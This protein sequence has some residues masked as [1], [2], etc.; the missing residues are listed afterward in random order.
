M[1]KKVKKV[2]KSSILSK[3]MK[4]KKP[5]HEKLNLKQ[6]TMH[7]VYSLIFIFLTSLFVFSAFG[8]GGL[9]G[10]YLYK[11]I[12]EYFG[13][14]YYVFP[15]IFL[16]IAIIF[17]KGLKKDFTRV[18]TISSLILFFSVLGFIDLVSGDGGKIGF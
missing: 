7:I 11:N 4:V 10:E 14:G 15:L 9:L 17:F 8:K 16:M 13:I 3:N 6:E 2:K 18:K 12:S 1:V 5:L